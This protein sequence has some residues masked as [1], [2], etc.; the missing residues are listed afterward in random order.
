MLDINI[1]KKCSTRGQS[2]KKNAWRRPSGVQF[3][4]AVEI[5]KDQIFHHVITGVQN[6]M[7][8]RAVVKFPGEL[9]L[10]SPTFCLLSPPQNTM[11]ESRVSFVVRLY[12]PSIILQPSRC[13]YYMTVRCWLVS[14]RVFMERSYC[15]GRCFWCIE[16]FARALVF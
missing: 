7:I 9:K 13:I 2:G 6:E 15:P 12:S 11:R 14:L 16:L 8:P 5:K 3:E 10:P 1:K 4:R